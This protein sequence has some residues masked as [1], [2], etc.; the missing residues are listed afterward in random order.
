MWWLGGGGT[1]IPGPNKDE[2][3]GGMVLE[4]AKKGDALFGG[5]DLD[6]V[7]ISSRILNNGLRMVNALG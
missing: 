6:F 3:L 5:E 1:S 4:G 7:E 2:S